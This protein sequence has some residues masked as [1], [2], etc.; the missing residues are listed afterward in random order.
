MKRYLVLENG[1]VFEGNAFGADRDVIAEIVFNTAVTGYV[2]TLSD[3]RYIGQAICQTFPLIGNY[4]VNESDADGVPVCVSAY[5][6]RELS[7]IASNFRSEGELDA[8]LKKYNVPGLSG[9]DTR[10]LTKLL[11]DEGTMNGMITSD[12]AKADLDAIRNFRITKAV[13]AASTKEVYTEGDGSIK[14]AL[15][16]L[17]SK[18]GIIR[19]LVRHGA[20]VTV[21]PHTASA[22]E[23]LAINPDGIVLSGGPGDPA[24]CGMEVYTVKALLD[25]G[26]PML[27]IGLGHQ[28]LALANG[29]S[30]TKLK[31]G[32]RGGSYPTKTSEESG[33]LYITAQNHGYAVASETVDPTVAE[34]IF[35]NINDKSNEGLLYKNIPA[36]SVQFTPA[37]ITGPNDTDF[38]YDRFFKMLE[39]K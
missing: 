13:E 1:T 33:R 4:G 3:A 7:D 35:R 32:H 8:Y 38:V 6:V 39:L 37:A 20:S 23:I 11:R 22:D 12:P 24:E 36:I 9:I 18:N 2:E 27:A 29:F 16:D 34:E 31:H 14:L 26:I 25:S 17:G 28:L 15:L 30:T 5:I 19:D 10:K 21:F